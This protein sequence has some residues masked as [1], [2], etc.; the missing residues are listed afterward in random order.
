M[1][2]HYTQGSRGGVIRYV[3]RDGHTANGIYN[4][5]LPNMRGLLMTNL[6]FE[7][8]VL[9]Q[10]YEL[11][12]ELQTALVTSYKNRLSK[13]IDLLYEFISA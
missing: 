9:Q 4:G 3:A 13:Q 7:E 8:L 6:E 11:R 1:L 2:L 5:R 10:I 12:I